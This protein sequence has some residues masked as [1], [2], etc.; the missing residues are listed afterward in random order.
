MKPRREVA[1]AAL[2][3]ALAV[4]VL[5]VYVPALHGTLLWDDAAHVTRP[6][7]QPL[8][9]LW[10][11]WFE[12][13]ATQQYYPLLHSAFWFEHRLWGDHVLGYHLVNVGLHILSALCVVGIMRQLRLP[14]A[15]LAGWI[16]ALH[17]VAVESVAW[18]TEQ[19]NTLSTL[20]GLAATILYL[21][22]DA[23]RLTSVYAMAS[24]MFVAA[25]LSKTTVAT[26]PA[27]LLV[28]AW[29]RRGRIDWR[30]DVLPLAP[31]LVVGALAGVFTAW[32]ERTYIG[33]HGAAFSLSW[34]ARCLLAGRIVWFYAATV[35]WP[36]HLTFNYPRW[37]IDPSNWRQYL[38]P[39]G[40]AAVFVA[41]WAVRRRTRATLAVVLL[42]VG[43]LVPV[44]GFLN[45]Y[46]FVYSYVADHFAYGAALT[47]IMPVA[48]GLTLTFRRWRSL[49]L[50]MCAA[51]LLCAT[52]GT[53]TF[54]QSAMYADVET[55][56]KTTIARNP[57]SWLSY[58]NLG[59]LLA[60]DPSRIGEALE[61]F[62]ASV[63][64]APDRP[65][66]HRNLA[67]ALWQTADL[68]AS[69][70]EYETLLAIDAH[71]PED[72]VRYARVLMGLHAADRAEQ[73]VRQALRLDPNSAEAHYLMGRLLDPTDHVTAIAEYRT[74]VR[75]RPVY[76]EAHVGLANL[77]AAA[78]ASREEAIAEYE[79]ALDTRPDYFEA[80][81]NLG[82]LLIDVGGRE[83]AAVEH[84]SHAARLRPDDPHVRTN[85]AIA[86]L[87]LPDHTADAV[88]ELREAVR[89]APDL[90]EPRE[91]LRRALRTER[92]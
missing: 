83:R 24:A 77:L 74:A 64:I 26:I 79:R 28:C 68:E 11:I 76:P 60:N 5:A 32:V 16:F 58:E 7:L 63:R 39:L 78:P 33:A 88:A 2:A 13:G 57:Q 45:V 34:L 67:M 22:F 25:L 37:G 55:L 61:D 86:L 18:I 14:G 9:G 6:D 69:A 35:A 84:L 92:Q 46:P 17:P 36:Q 73:Q 91:L 29:W 30:R 20:L 38:Y 65:A 47:L 15:W 87:D 80:E 41:A 70:V 40:L 49:G 43:T 48:C 31:W 90:P 8:S 52:L 75:L 82:S 66:G 62:R 54:H 42:F 4:A 85:L 19:K 53:L 50:S 56:Y 44:L 23:R 10:R 89:L 81:Y 51:A 1:D 71:D 72:H 59:V 12:L 3:L 27:A 21:R